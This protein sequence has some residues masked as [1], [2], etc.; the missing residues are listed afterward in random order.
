MALSLIKQAMEGALKPLAHICNVLF[1]TGTFQNQMKIA[2]VILKAQLFKLQA[3]LNTA[4]TI[5]NIG[6]GFFFN[7]RMD[8]FLVKHNLFSESQYELRVNR[9][10]SQA[11]IES[12]EESTDAI[13]NE[14][15]Q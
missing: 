4:K 13:D 9:S 2:N 10:I 1:Q 11:I 5:K 15:M 3:C 14:N 7:N 6:K 12:I 8:A